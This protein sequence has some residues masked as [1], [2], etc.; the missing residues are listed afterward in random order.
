MTALVAVPVFKC[1][2][3]SGTGAHGQ[4]VSAPVAEVCSEARC[5]KRAPGCRKNALVHNE[6]PMHSHTREIRRYR[7]RGAL[8]TRGRL[9]ALGAFENEVLGDRGHE[10]GGECCLTWSW[11]EATPRERRTLS[12]TSRSLALTRH[13][14]TTERLVTSEVPCSS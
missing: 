13:F 12:R 14:A 2:D 10:D 9:L 8:P 7:A 6:L 3:V 1:G 11:R 4:G 5:R